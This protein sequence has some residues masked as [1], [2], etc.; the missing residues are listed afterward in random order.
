MMRITLLIVVALLT[1]GSFAQR[2]KRDTL[3]F[4]QY[5]QL[6]KAHHPFMQRAGLLP[7]QAEANLMLARGGF[8]P[9]IF[10]DV[11]QKYFDGDQYYNI[12]SA[13]V[14]IPTWFGLSFYTG[15]DQTSGYYLNPQNRTPNNGLVYAGA[16]WTLGQ[17][18][19]I[20]KRRADLQQ[21]KMFTQIAEQERVM[22]V[23]QLLLDASLAYWDWFAAFNSYSFVNDAYGVTQIR[24]NAVKQ[25]AFL[26]ERAFV[27]TLE[28]SIQLQNLDLLRQD[29]QLQ[30]LNRRLEC[31][32]FLWADGVVP[33]E[34][35]DN[36]APSKSKDNK[37]SDDL[38]SIALQ[39]N[40]IVGNHPE[41][42][43]DLLRIDQQQIDLRLKR[44]MLKPVA[45]LKY[46]AINQPIGSDLLANY[47][48]QNYTWGFDFGIPILL[49][50]E[51]AGVK[52]SQLRLQDMNFALDYKRALILMKAQSA[53]NEW[54]ITTKQLELYQRNLKD[55]DRLLLA[56]RTR[57][58]NG[59]SSVFLVNTREMSLVNAQVKLYE[60]IS[61]SQKSIFKTYYSLALMENL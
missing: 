7:M 35:N 24:F 29:F 31:G 42:Q 37:F 49:R 9:K 60:F 38:N 55:I 47:A 19:F 58:D 11:S 32:V 30:E 27:D 36:L 50:K 53:I 14:G 20:D 3:H 17:G 46:N 4:E 18:L 41:I 21:A 23:N 33:V 12:I 43:R 6:V 26:G 15:Y 34:I 59:E 16:Q 61:K 48:I 40:N 13:G 8:D 10:A 2:N 54:Q 52:L 22:L 45:N 28:L 57:F 44:E 1:F 51:R 5:L 56:E 25:S 39:L